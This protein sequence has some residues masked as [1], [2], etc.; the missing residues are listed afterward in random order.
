MGFLRKIKIAYLANNISTGGSAKSLLLLF[1]SLENY[2]IE[3]YLYVTRSSNEE[4]KK[5]IVAFCKYFKII[6]IIEI[7]EFEFQLKKCHF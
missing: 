6:K 5:Q 3:I 4:M 1:K 7:R 2:N